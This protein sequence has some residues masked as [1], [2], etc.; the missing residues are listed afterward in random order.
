[1][2]KSVILIIAIISTSAHAME[3]KHAQTPYTPS[4]PRIVRD[5]S[6]IPTP[7]LSSRLQHYRLKSSEELARYFATDNE[8]RAIRNNEIPIIQISLGPQTMYFYMAPTNTCWAFGQL[9]EKD[10]LPTYAKHAIDNAPIQPNQIT[11]VAIPQSAELFYV[12][13]DNGKQYLF[14]KLITKK[15][16]TENAISEASF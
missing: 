5:L 14:K 16:P 10:K 1:M 15:N 2:K 7:S 13:D 11:V 4:N 8:I 12:A 9:L 6:I 3:T